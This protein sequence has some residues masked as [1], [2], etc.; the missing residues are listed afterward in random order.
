MRIISKKFRLGSVVVL[1]GC[2][3]VFSPALSKEALTME[4]LKSA[5]RSS[6]E[7]TVLNIVV[8]TVVDVPIALQEG[9]MPNIMVVEQGSQKTQPALL[10]S[11]KK[12]L[13]KASDSTNSSG[14][15]FLVDGKMDN[16]QEY[17]VNSNGDEQHIMIT[18]ASDKIIT[19]SAL[20]LYL[21]QFVALPKTIE[22]V[23]KING[24]EKTVLARQNVSRSTIN[25]PQT[26]AQEFA[27]TFTYVQ[28]LR[29]R[30]MSF[31]QDSSANTKENNLRFL[32]LP[33]KK[34][35]AYFNADRYVSAYTGEIPDLHESKDVLF[36][37]KTIV[38][39]NLAYQKSDVDKD[40]VPDEM[41]NCVREK[42]ADQGD[43]NGNGRGDAC[44][45]FDRDGVINSKDNCRDVPNRD[46]KDTDLDGIGDVCDATESRLLQN[47]KWLP[48]AMILV[49]AGVVGLLFAKTMK[50]KK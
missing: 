1:A 4:E 13:L 16:F 28:P 31:S 20:N 9:A 8:P 18:I 47:Q 11:E 35:T 36:L 23:A 33:D 25:F 6:A 10:L 50:T 40:G 19:T 24:V 3:V 32:A 21:D 44:D 27:I 12:N 2:L 14:A 49:V 42:N 41:D 22:I 17:S 46:Q 7:V 29:I 45:D 5:F 39:D 48:L 30:E 26:S 37:K 38:G 34:Y 43:L 15:I